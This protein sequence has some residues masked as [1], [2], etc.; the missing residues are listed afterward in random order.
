MMVLHQFAKRFLPYVFHYTLII[1]S[2]FTVIQV[3]G[4]LNLAVVENDRNGI[5]T[6]LKDTALKLQKS[7]SPDDASLYLKL[8]KKCLAEKHFDG[9]ELWLEDVEAIT[10]IVAGEA[11][12][13]QNGITYFHPFEFM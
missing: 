1:F 13:V 10:K 12:T 7:T 4:Q 6:A 5:L 2:L 8:F 3:L 11:E 9:S